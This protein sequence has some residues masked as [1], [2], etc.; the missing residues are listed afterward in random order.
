MSLRIGDI[1]PYFAP[2]S[3][4]CTIHF[5]VHLG[6][7]PKNGDNIIISLAVKDEDAVVK[8][9]GYKTIKPYLRTTSQPK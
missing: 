7:N 9:P 8:F 6:E 1:G 2:D 5:H 4:K 3:S